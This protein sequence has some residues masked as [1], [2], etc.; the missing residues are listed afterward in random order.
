MNARQF[1]M[2]VLLLLCLVCVSCSNEEAK[3]GC[4]TCQLTGVNA[5]TP[6]LDGEWVL[7]ST[8]ATAG[9]GPLNALF[10]TE[11]VLTI[12]QK[13]NVIEFGL[14]DSCG[15]PIPGGEGRVDASQVVALGTQITRGVTS[16]CSLKL[17]QLRTGVLEVPPNI[18]SGSDVLTLSP[19]D[20]PSSDCGASLPC[21]VTGTFTAVRCPRSGCQVT[22]AQ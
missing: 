1:A 20:D 15:R 6:L 19:S 7:T 18:C 4:T 16:T 9:C 11:S 10:P 5:I 3:D 8:P 2:P 12:T 21:N 14:A 13:G 17:E 22:C